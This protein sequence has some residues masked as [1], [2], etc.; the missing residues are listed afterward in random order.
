MNGLAEVFFEDILLEVYN[1]KRRRDCKKFRQIDQYGQSVKKI[2]VWNWL[3]CSMKSVI[4]EFRSKYV[5]CILVRVMHCRSTET[6]K[7]S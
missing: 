3:N 1:G 5:V 4:G 2:G 6:K 7:Q